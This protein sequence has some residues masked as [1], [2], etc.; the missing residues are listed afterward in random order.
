MV[1]Y[2]NKLAFTWLEWT[3]VTNVVYAWLEW[4]VVS[5]IGLSLAEMGRVQTNL[6]KSSGE[7]DENEDEDWWLQVYKN[8][9]D[10]VRLVAPSEKL[11]MEKSASVIDEMNLLGAL[12]YGIC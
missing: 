7:D 9:C 1:I 6:L 10:S 8:R 5:N 11:N 12:F 2:Q 3:A 4:V